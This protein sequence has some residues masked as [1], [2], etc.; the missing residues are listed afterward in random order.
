MTPIPAESAQSTFANTI[1][2][3][4]CG[5][6]HSEDDGTVLTEVFLSPMSVHEQSAYF[7]SLL[8]HFNHVKG[9]QML[10]N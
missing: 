6:L 10:P 9:H 3:C 4:S 2:A 1:K 7:C 5:H 8:S